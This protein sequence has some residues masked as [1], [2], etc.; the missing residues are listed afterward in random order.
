MSTLTSSST[1]AQV[2][3]AYDDNAS[4]EEDG[5]RTKA[6]AF[7]TACKFLIRRK[8]KRMEHDG[9]SSDFDA[10]AIRDEMSAARNWL[11]LN[12]ASTTAAVRYA[13][14]AGYRD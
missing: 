1:D 4:Y 3:A 11:A 2:W 8:P 10:E 6:L 5:D 12:P 14:L 13:D 7:L 9:R